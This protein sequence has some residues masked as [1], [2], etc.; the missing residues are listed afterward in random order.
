M[1]TVRKKSST[2]QKLRGKKLG[3]NARSPRDRSPII[4]NASGSAPPESR[5]STAAALMKHA[6]GWSGN[7]LDDVIGT[8]TD[9]RLKTR[10]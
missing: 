7:D 5:R 9:T 3:K 8:V 2:Q 10:F 1:K 4:I 6:S